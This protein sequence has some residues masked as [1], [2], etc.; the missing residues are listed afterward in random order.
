MTDRAGDTGEGSEQSQPSSS[1]SLPYRWTQTLAEVHIEVPVP[2]GTRG[3][4]VHLQI[5]PKSLK[6]AIQGGGSGTQ[7]IREGELFAEIATDESTW[8]LENQETVSVHLEKSNRQQWWPHVWQQDP[9]IDVSKIQPENSK[10]SDLDGETR[11]MVEKMMV[12]GRSPGEKGA[13]LLPTIDTIP[14]V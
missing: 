5:N 9:K 2:K 4:Q 14:Q 13:N 1:T 7:T 6:V 3:K 11:G 8:T 12:G 10:L